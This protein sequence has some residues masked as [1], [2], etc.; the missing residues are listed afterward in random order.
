MKIHNI[1]GHILRKIIKTFSFDGG[2]F[3]IFWEQ[4]LRLCFFAMNYHN[5]LAGFVNSSGEIFVLKYTNKTRQDNY[6]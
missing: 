3:Q 4:I 5:D 2:K 1:F 6:L